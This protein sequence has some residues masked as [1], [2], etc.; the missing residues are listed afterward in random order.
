ML[1]L[2]KIEWLKLKNYRTFWILFILYLASIIGVNYI[3][4]EVQQS[5]YNAKQA[6][7]MAQMIVGNIPYSFPT[8]WQMTAYVSSFLLFIPG[9]LVIISLSNEYSYKTHRQ[10]IIDGWSR[11]NFI[12]VKML[13][14]IILA[15]ISAVFVVLTAILFGL[16]EGSNSFSTDKMI[17]I[18]YFFI[19]ALSYNMVALLITTLVKRGGLAI[20]IYFLYAVV[21]ENVLKLVLNYYFDT[22]GKYLPL[23][24][25]DELIPAPVFEN[26]QKELTKPVNYTLL[27]IMVVLYLC[28]YFYFTAKKFETDDL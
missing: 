22:V 13:L 24:S 15:A 25:T 18:V 4:Y 26:I 23:Q 2:L 6:K 20:G 9:L 8:V 1:T 14:T 19:Q 27:Y 3:A 12:S 16:I 28:A 5:I 11:R 17:Y 21:I 10:N 7:G